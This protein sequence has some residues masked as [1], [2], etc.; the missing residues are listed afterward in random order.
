M[1]VRLVEILCETTIAQDIYESMQT[2]WVD[3]LWQQNLE[4]DMSSVRFLLSTDD[5]QEILEYIDKRWS[6]SPKWRLL[7]SSIHGTMPAIEEDTQ[8]V[9]HKST[10]SEKRINPKLVRIPVQ[11]LY[12]QV[13]EWAT[14]SPNFYILF[15]LSAIVAA[16]WLLNNNVSIIIWSMVIAPFL[17]PNV[18]LALGTT[19]ADMDLIKKSSSLL[20][21][22]VWIVFAIA[23]VWWLIEPEVS[24]LVV[25][26]N[27]TYSLILVAF[28]S[29]VAAILSLM[30]GEA[31][32]L[33]WVMV[34]VALLPPLVLCWLLLWG[35]HM[36]PAFKAFLLFAANVI[37][38]NLA[39]V[40]TFWLAWIKPTYWREAKKAAKHTRRAMV[41]WWVWLL[42]LVAAT[43][44]LSI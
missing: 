1:S 41:V 26:A 16:I 32:A 15:A 40:M 31:S 25:N 42:I 20:I 2:Q 39:W 35:G 27:I 21:Y 44:L 12:N 10:K 11:E 9:D 18:W 13:S 36:F 7:L 22:G 38:L 8:E 4:N 43:Y 23:V 14:H 24:S 6:G 33:V 19:L 3:D 34:A 30:R 28:V 29:W 37:C 17:W 5:S